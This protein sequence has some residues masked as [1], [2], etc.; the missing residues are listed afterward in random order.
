[1][2]EILPTKDS[3][4]KK[5]VAKDDLCLIRC[6]TRETIQHVLWGCPSASDVQ[7]RCGRRLQKG[8]VGGRPVLHGCDAAARDEDEMAMFSY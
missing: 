3:L 4:L 1:M 2:G 8:L 6:R 7:S 5:K